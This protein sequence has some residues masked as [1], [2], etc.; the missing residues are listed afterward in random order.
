MSDNNT[1]IRLEDV[2]FAYPDDGP[3]LDKLNFSLTR[4]E[5]IS[6][7]GP[8]G[9]GKTTLFYIIM[10]LLKP[11]SGR[12][13]IFGNTICEEK[14]FRSVREKI[15]LLFQD[16]D[17]QLFSPTVIED[18]AFGP[19]NLGKPPD[20]ALLIARDTLNKL[21]IAGLEGRVAYKLS[22]GE[23]RLAALATV[24]AMKPEILILDEPDS[25]LDGPTTDRII[26][27]LNNSNL[28]CIITSHNMDFLLKTTNKTYGIE[29][30]R[31]YLEEEATPHIHTHIHKGGK[32]PHEHKDDL[33]A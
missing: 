14:A 31:I 32:Y 9:S 6:L 11:T 23:K 29:K 10:G 16:S 8:N 24:L 17:D 21:G 7:I 3:V 1:L 4:G 20:E 28:S 18:V 27:V 30:G 2:S 5:R 33:D 15:G 19:L 12:I 22:G 26:D 13:E 25:G